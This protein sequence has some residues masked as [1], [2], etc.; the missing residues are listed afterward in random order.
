MN[1]RPIALLIAVPALLSAL[2]AQ[3]HDPK[4]HVKGGEQPDCAAVQDMDHS[5]MDIKDPVMQAMMQKCME[6]MHRDEEGSHEGHA[7]R[8][9]ADHCKHNEKANEKRPPNTG[10]ENN[11]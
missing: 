5:K 8:G 10:T 4:E 2:S 6:A 9:D 11:G 3:A 1:N 7:E